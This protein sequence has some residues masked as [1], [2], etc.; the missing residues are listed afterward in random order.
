MYA[1]LMQ[2]DSRLSLRNNRLTEI[3]AALEWSAGWGWMTTDRWG[4]VED[5]MRG[6]GGKRY[7]GWGWKTVYPSFKLLRP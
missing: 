2:S 5:G 7:A 4:G 3:G 1:D 6:G